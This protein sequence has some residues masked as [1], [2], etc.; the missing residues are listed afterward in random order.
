MTGG[1]EFQNL[2]VVEP[3]LTE[4]TTATEKGN[5]NQPHSMRSMVADGDF[6]RA[7]EEGSAMLGAR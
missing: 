7:C 4:M 6:R 3:L 1:F 2:L 5:R